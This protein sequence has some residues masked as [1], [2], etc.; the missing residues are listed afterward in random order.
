MKRK[1]PLIIGTLL[2]AS[3][4]VIT[5]GL[6]FI[7]RI[8][9]SRLIGS[10]GMGIYQLIFPV[11]GICYS[12]CCGALQTA[13]SKFTAESNNK[14]Y[15]RLGLLLSLTL[16][17]L[18]TFILWNSANFISTYFLLEE[19]CTS[20]LKI[21]SLSLP[22]NSIHSCICGYYLGRKKTEIPA[23]SQ[24]LEQS[25]RMIFLLMISYLLQTITV[26]TAILA[27]VIGEIASA[28]F[29]SLSI[30]ISF[31]MNQDTPTTLPIFTRLK[32]L[33][34]L[35]LPLSANRFILSLLQSIEAIMIPSRL[36]LSGLSQATA[37]GIYGVFCGM[38]MP[39]ILFPNALTSALSMMLLPEVASEQAK[40]NKKRI[41]YTA[42]RSSEYCLYMGILCTGIFVY[43][44]NLLGE[45]FFPNTQAG[46]FIS[47]L[48]WICPFLYLNNTYTSILN[49]LGKASLTFTH[50]LAGTVFRLFFVVFFI[51]KHGII[52][53]FLG[54]LLG[55]LLTCG[56]NYFS[57]KK[58]VQLQY[59]ALFSL[60]RPIVIMIFILVS[61]QTIPF[62]NHSSFSLLIVKGSFISISYLLLLF[63]TRRKEKPT[64][65]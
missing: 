63:I 37:L 16:S 9:L 17:V 34:S 49:G 11:L 25:V 12:I 2:L 55:N 15:Y 38:A 46:I 4:S 53:H 23:I 19:R 59:N 41:T 7:Y 8:W 3:A 1:N 58:L 57:L 44:G 18:C 28:I 36:Q 51:P 35:S 29:C 27:L 30:Q 64:N 14:S 10:E 60:F 33:L 54:I 39:F 21:L 40:N 26:E 61:C 13:I 65:V 20:S 22:F 52:G 48:A 6:G 24:L 45:L 50:H 47:T 62:G 56:L 5:K 42:T 43:L 32:N 31:S